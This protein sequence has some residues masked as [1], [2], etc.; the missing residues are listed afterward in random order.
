MCQQQHRHSVRLGGKAQPAG[1]NKIDLIEHREHE[2]PRLQTLLDGPQHV[3][4]A[5]R[6]DQ[7]EPLR[8]EP[9]AHEPWSMRSPHLSDRAIRRAP[10]DRSLGCLRILARKPNGQPPGEA[11]RGIPIVVHAGLDLVDAAA[12]EPPAAQPCIDDG[13]S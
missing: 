9:Q 11:E 3:D 5:A 6:L 8:V 13:G 10:Q 2:H 7:Q 4:R 1:G 12:I